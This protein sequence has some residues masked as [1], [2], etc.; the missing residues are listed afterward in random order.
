MLQFAGIFALLHLF[1]TG[2]PIGRW[3]AA[4]VVA[5]VAYFLTT[6]LVGVL[7][8]GPMSLTGRPNPFGVG[9]AWFSDAWAVGPA[10]MVPF[11]VVGLWVV[12]ARWRDA[13]LVGRAQLKWFYAAA[14]WVAITALVVAIPS[15]DSASRPVVDLDAAFASTIDEIRAKPN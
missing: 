11:V 14:V 4:V 8:P 3:H 10:G 1:P 13:G 2:R 6:A 7:R 5:M 9:P 12:V 15:D